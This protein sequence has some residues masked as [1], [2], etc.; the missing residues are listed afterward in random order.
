MFKVMTV[1]ECVEI[2]VLGRRNLKSADWDYC[3]VPYMML[4]A[5]R[6]GPL[7][8]PNFTL[9]GVTCHPH[10]VKKQKNQH[11]VV[12]NLYCF[13]QADTAVSLWVLSQV[14]KESSPTSTTHGMYDLSS[15]F[16]YLDHNI[17]LFFSVFAL[18]IMQQNRNF[19][20]PIATMDVAIKV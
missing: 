12:T 17:L 4:L 3:V 6:N 19:S 1:Y 11:R 16:V 8:L 13:V 9:I 20:V 14:C 18:M 5:G 10:G 2:S 7:L 15:F